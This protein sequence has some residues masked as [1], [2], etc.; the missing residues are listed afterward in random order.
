MKRKGIV[1]LGAFLF[2]GGLLFPAVRQVR[3]TAARA[4]IYAEPNRS[5]TRIDIV[6]KGTLLNLFQ[7]QKVKDVW[8]YVSYVSARYGGRMSGF[9]LDTAV[10]PVLEGEPTAELPPSPSPPPKTVVDSKAKVPIPEARKPVAAEAPEVPKKAEPVAAA[11]PDIPKEKPKVV[12]YSEVT[13]ITPLPRAKRISLPRRTA[14]LQDKPWAVLQP[15][16]PEPEKPPAITTTPAAPVPPKP[17]TVETPAVPE[18]VEITPAP[19]PEIMKEQPKVVEYTVVTGI[20]RAPRAKRISLPRRTASLQDKPWAVLQPPAPEPEKPLTAA[21]K[22]VTAETPA[23]PEKVEI[24]PAP[25]S[26]LPKEKPRAAPSTPPAV[27]EAPSEKKAPKAA[28]PAKAEPEKPRPAPT[29]TPSAP[30]V[31]PPQPA[32]MPTTGRRPARLGLGLGYGP[33]FGG[34][35]GSLQFNLNRSLALHA[36]YGVYPTTVVYSET[37]WVENETLWSAGLRFYPMPSSDKLTP[38][39]DA[40][41]G[42]LRVEAAQVITGIYEYSYIYSYEQKVLWGPSLLA[43]L[44]IRFGRLA[45]SGGIGASYSLTDWDVLTSRIFFTFEAGLGVRL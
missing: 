10:E 15:P 11:V 45:L 1:F 3:V 22:P 19:K 5:S 34:A 23:V 24:K 18:K 26:D 25:K 35:G 17:V 14:S 41:Y 39:I 32:R 29:S 37:D 43:G 12:E 7:L 2:G 27:R 28:E 40:Q 30:Q 4:A 13:G 8:Y 42:G 44:E 9:I 31:K 36:G 21:P 33:S 6:V 38:Y 16:A 20:T